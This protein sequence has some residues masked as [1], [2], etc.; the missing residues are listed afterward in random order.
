MKHLV[1]ATTIVL[2][3]A[4]PANA[5]EVRFVG[6]LVTTSATN[7]AYTTAGDSRVSQYRPP[8]EAGNPSGGG[9]TMMSSGGGYAVQFP[10]PHPALN[11]FQTVSTVEVGIAPAVVELGKEALPTFEPLGSGC[12]IRKGEQRH[13]DC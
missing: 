13:D 3:A 12:R 5:A 9:L 2:G 11:T 8:G 4:L 6:A 7:C 10:G 1:L